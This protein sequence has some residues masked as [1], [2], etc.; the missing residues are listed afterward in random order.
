MSAA[1]IAQPYARLPVAVYQ[2]DLVRRD[3]GQHRRFD[4]PAGVQVG[5]AS[6]AEMEKEYALHNKRYDRFL[7]FF[8]LGFAV[9]LLAALS[10]SVAAGKASASD[11]GIPTARRKNT[12]ASP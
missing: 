9:A 2:H 12:S 10:Y 5:G 8:F 6:D 11:A 7:R 3:L 1:D 4:E